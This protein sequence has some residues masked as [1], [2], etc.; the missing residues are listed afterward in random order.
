MSTKGYLLPEE[1]AGQ[2]V[3]GT[4]LDAERQLK[5]ARHVLRG[6]PRGRC[7]TPGA[8]NNWGRLRISGAEL[9]VGVTPMGDRDN[10]DVARGIVD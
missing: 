9:A 3:S 8:E 7:L 2:N 10:L 5:S 4:F 6:A 1:R